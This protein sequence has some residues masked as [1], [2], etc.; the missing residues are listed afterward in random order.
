MNNR[1]FPFNISLFDMKCCR[2]PSKQ[3]GK[4]L[5]PSLNRDGLAQSQSDLRT[6]LRGRIC[7]GKKNC[8]YQSLNR[9]R[10]PLSSTTELALHCAV[11]NRAR[12]A[13]ADDKFAK[14][15]RRLNEFV[16]RSL[17]VPRARR[18]VLLRYSGLEA[19]HTGRRFCD[20]KA[21]VLPAP[22]KTAARSACPR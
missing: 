10:L 11:L 3:F 21:A 2:D 19:A 20:T 9:D 13:C 22:L 6:V 17:C 18:S 1:P 16:Q 4:R 15:E 12:A 8:V 5:C 14:F 7:K